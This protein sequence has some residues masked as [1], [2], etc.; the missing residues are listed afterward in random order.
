M[1]D[2]VKQAK[3]A[4]RRLHAAFIA[5]MSHTDKPYPDDERWTPWTRFLRPAMDGVDAAID[6]LLAEIERL[7]GSTGVQPDE[8][9]GGAVKRAEDFAAATTDEERIAVLTRGLPAGDDQ[10]QRCPVHRIPDCSP[11]LN[12]CSWRPGPVGVT[13][14][15]HELC[16][17]PGQHTPHGIV[18]ADGIVHACP[19][20]TS[21]EKQQ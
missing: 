18:G 4:K 19:A 3:D 5:T 21:E 11:L 20:P 7:Q 12:G 15:R 16:D 14:T 1:S 8:P 13:P 17:R 2:I 10:Q 9:A 6:A